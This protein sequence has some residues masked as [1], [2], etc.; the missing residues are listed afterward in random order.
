MNIENL[1]PV[2]PGDVLVVTG[3]TGD[4]DAV[5]EQLAEIHRVALVAAGD[6]PVHVVAVGEGVTLARLTD[7]ERRLLRE[8]LNRD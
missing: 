2:E 6:G 7:D 8:A 5:Q 1:G 4:P 3:I